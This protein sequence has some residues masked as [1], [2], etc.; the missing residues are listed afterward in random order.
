[1]TVSADDVVVKTQ[2]EGVSVVPRMQVVKWLLRHGAVMSADV[3]EAVYEVA[4]RSATWR[5]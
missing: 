1:M 4:R 5:P 3:I 2:P